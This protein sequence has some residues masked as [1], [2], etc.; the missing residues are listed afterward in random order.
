MSKVEIVLGRKDNGLAIEC[1]TI[2]EACKKIK[3]MSYW[4]DA[5]DHKIYVDGKKLA[6]AKQTRIGKK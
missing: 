1:K 6:V 4:F 2:A 5:G 3:D